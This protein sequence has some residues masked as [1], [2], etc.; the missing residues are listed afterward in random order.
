[1][2]EPRDDALKCGEHFYV[3]T[4]SL[5]L[6]WVCSVVSKISSLLSSLRKTPYNLLRARSLVELSPSALSR[7]LRAA[8]TRMPR[9]MAVW[10]GT[11]C[12]G[13]STQDTRQNF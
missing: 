2:Q 3:I 7:G 10:R 1:M 11:F 8:P 4:L 13:V 5:R 9:R 6:L 12:T